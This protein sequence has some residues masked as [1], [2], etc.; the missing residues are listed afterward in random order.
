[1][2]GHVPTPRE[3]TERMVEELFDEHPP[4]EDDRILYPGVGDGPFVSAVKRYCLKRDLPTPE[5]TAIE[6]D[7]ELLAKAREQ[8]GDTPVDFLEEDFLNISE[9]D[10]GQFDYVIGNP[11]YVPIEGLSEEEKERYKNNFRTAEQRFDLYIL[12]FEQA[13]NLLAD[14]GR[15]VFITPEKFEYTHTTSELRRLMASYHV[16]RIEHVREDTFDG[17]VT[18]PTI[19]TI[20]DRDADETR[21][22]RRDGTEDTVELP[23][24]GASWA[25]YIR[26][27][28][29]DAYDYDSGVTLGDVTKRISC[30]LATGRDTIFVQSEEEVPEQL[31]EEGWTYPTTS[32]KQLTVNDGPD[33]N[34]LIICPYDENGNLT[35]ED[36]LGVYGDWAELH[37]DELESR[38]CVKKGKVWYSWHENPPMDDLYG[39]EKILCKDVCDPPE[40][41]A[42]RE[43]DIVPRHSVYYIIPDDGVDLEDLLDYLNSPKARAWIE[44][45]AQKAANDYYRMQSKVLRKLPVPEEFGK[46]KQTKLI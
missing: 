27:G 34:D 46:T 45:N 44:E 10:I 3:I 11:P 26:S 6:L 33:S 5:G 15:L 7:P 28:E 38:S 30:G 36:E 41:W 8:N 1:M 21:I 40:F 19:T 29:T 18:Y 23:R 35:T 31:V 17:H 37:R 24:D 16:E 14:Q 4:E 39:V 22:I 9:E 20:H 2:K 13:L 25:S 32:G 42:D 43:G 12:F